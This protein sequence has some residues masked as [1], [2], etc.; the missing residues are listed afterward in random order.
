MVRRPPKSTLSPYTTLF[1]SA[2]ARDHGGRA[3]QRPD[4]VDQLAVTGEAVAEGA[5]A[6][7][8]PPA[9]LR[10]VEPLGRGAVGAEGRLLRRPV[11]AQQAEAAALLVVIEVVHEDLLD[12][13]SRVRQRDRQ[14]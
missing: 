1:R 9:P 10:A 13:H 3:A 12:V 7:V 2:A 4:H 11:V 6:R 14:P 5:R 8:E